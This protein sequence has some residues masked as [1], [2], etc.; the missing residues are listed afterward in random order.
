M[1]RAATPLIIAYVVSAWVV[2]SLRLIL[3]YPGGFLLLAA[4][5]IVFVVAIFVYG[6]A[7]LVL[8]IIYQNRELAF[9]KA[10]RDKSIREMREWSSHKY[11]NDIASRLEDDRD[12]TLRDGEE[13][14]V[15]VD[16]RPKNTH[17]KYLP[18]FK[19]F[20]AGFIQAT[21]ITVSLGELARLWGVDI[22]REGGHP[23]ASFLDTILVLVIAYGAYR[24]FN[25]Y[26]DFKIVEEGGTLDS[27]VGK[28]GEGEGEGG[29]GQSRLATLLPIFRNVLVSL[30]VAISLVVVLS[31]LG[32][33]CRTAVRW[34]RC[35]RYCH[36]FWS[37][38][39][40]P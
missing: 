36:R 18:V 12:D 26:I 25:Q 8:E 38:D 5:I 3:G 40:D 2:A 23:L 19:P 1:A 20:F 37:S 7:T 33:G 6:V 32:C 17:R 21:V 16:D 14:T 11:S 31:N 10:R 15:Y 4:P 27:E 13:M 24:A 34:C 29:K 35:R 28:P 22:G 9:Y 30:I 39:P